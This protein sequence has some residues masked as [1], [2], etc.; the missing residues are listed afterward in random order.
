ML[1]F[2]LL[3][4]FI[5]QVEK[6]KMSVGK[7]TY[8]T[9]KKLL[10]QLWNMEYGK[11]MEKRVFSRQVDSRIS[12]QLNYFFLPSRRSYKSNISLILNLKKILYDR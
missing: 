4:V 3:Y 10:F 1:N 2:Q 9:A 7:I 6:L 8:L 5:D 11:H 12:P